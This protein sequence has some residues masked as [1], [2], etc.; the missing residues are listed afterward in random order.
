MERPNLSNL[1]AEVVAYIHSLENEL[2]QLRAN[3][4]RLPAART[5]PKILDDDQPVMS[6]SELNEPAEP[7]TSLH[8]I[9]VTANGIAKRTPRHLYNR[10]HRGGMGIFDLETDEDDPPA[11]L[12]IADED[13]NLLLITNYGRAF[14]LPVSAIPARPV[15]A[16]G[17]SI[18]KKFLLGDDEKLVALLTDQAQ[19][20]IA[21]LSQTG[22]V[23]L[24]RH[25]IFGEHMKP[26][27]SLFDYKQFGPLAS[28]CR[29]EGD[30]ELFIATRLGKAIRFSEKSVP[31]AGTVGIRLAA[32]DQAVAIA[33]IKAE[34][35]IFLLSADGKGA[36]RTMASF[37]ANKAP[38]AGG[39]IAINSEHVISA[40]CTDD[41]E[42]ILIIS[43]LSKI[44]RFRLEEV[45]P[46]DGVVQ[47][48]I[49]MTLRA[50]LPVAACVNPGTGVF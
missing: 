15:R 20:Y 40:L 35:S 1:P 18:V 50:D 11:L 6:F 19:G 21:L 27:T 4:V 34:S 25:H 31:P 29:T 22:M 26:G 49:C 17:E 23:R 30:G 7:P 14:R 42:D 45:P 16:R 12:T 32:N 48:V 43:E 9:T 24:L 5:K 13:Q 3:R 38:G 37:S 2:E 39:K 28:A 36:I 33:A 8:V 44:I 41:Q 10:Q 47:G 46:K